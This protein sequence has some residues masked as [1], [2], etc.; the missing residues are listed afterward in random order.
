MVKTC[1]PTRRK[2]W[3]MESRAHGGGKARAPEIAGVPDWKAVRAW[4]EGLPEVD[5]SNGLDTVLLG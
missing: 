1:S 2:G 4:R 3:M 5:D